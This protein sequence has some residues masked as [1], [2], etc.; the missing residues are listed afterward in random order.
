[1]STGPINSPTRTLVPRALHTQPLVPPHPAPEE[2][3][4][5]KNDR[6]SVNMPTGQTAPLAAVVAAAKAEMSKHIG[7]EVVAGA[8]AL[9]ERGYVYPRDLGANYCHKYSDCSK[10]VGCCADFVSDSYKE[11]SKSMG[12]PEYDIGAQMQAKGYN[13]HYC[14]S[15][16]AY[17]QKEQALLPAPKEGG[18][19]HVGDVVFFNWNNTGVADP[20]HVAVVTKVDANGFP[21]ELMESRHL[22]SPT[23]VTTLTPGDYRS[24][25]IVAIGRLKEATSDDEAANL[26]PPME[27]A[28]APGVASSW[29]SADARFN[30]N[31]SGNGGSVARTHESQ[32][33]RH[34]GT[35]TGYE[36]FRQR[37]F[38]EQLASS[39]GVAFSIM[40][41]LAKA[42]AS[43][44]EMPVEA[45]AKKAEKKGVPKAQ[46]LALAKKLIAKRHELRKAAPASLDTAKLLGKMSAA[47]IEKVLAER[48]SPLAGKNFG[49]FI[50]QMEQKYGVPA[51]QFLAQA[52]MES[53]LGKVGY[54]QGE[55]F[56][57]GNL[58][59]GSSWDGPTVSGGSGTFRS[60][61]SAEEG[62]EDY[63]KLLS[64]PSYQGKSLDEQLFTYA[65]PSENDSTLYTDTV[66]QLIAKW[67]APEPII[68]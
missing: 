22:N 54:T 5:S 8:R 27:V 21:I 17:F 10:S 49:E 68:N 62:I 11:M 30:G 59:P 46:A 16:V 19:A 38:L 28:L 37:E 33:R 24:E 31:A 7:N 40:D 18:K 64:G 2:L 20:H 25:H 29:G 26:L 43:E 39:Y 56:N 4:P 67:T 52:T 1:M 6:M 13:P 47:Q 60:Y 42:L 32:V 53:N 34:A 14:P 45:L 51:V 3:P 12:K 58:R 41:S 57:I 15:M 9:H 35:P 63:F 61:G 50:L 66:K 48:G 23:E 36:P 44:G 55:H 65:P